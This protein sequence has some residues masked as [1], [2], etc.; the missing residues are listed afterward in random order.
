M[1]CATLDLTCGFYQIKMHLDSISKTAFNTDR[2]H[3]EFV[4]LPFGLKN[5][6]ATFQRLMNNFLRDYINKIC[7]VYLDDVIILGTSLQVHCQSIK[8]VFQKLKEYNLKL[9]LDKCE[10]MSKKVAY[11]R[12]IVS[13]NG[14]KPNLDK[15]KAVK[16]FL[17][18]QTQ[19]DI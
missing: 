18:L 1:Y 15:I 6:A 7:L 9:Q 3:Y 2:E 5:A 10:F 11:L 4:R 8:K 19:K 13:Q 12:H 14:V 16:N 17:I